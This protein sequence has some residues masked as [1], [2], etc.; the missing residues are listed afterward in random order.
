MCE[1]CGKEWRVNKGKLV[2]VCNECI[3]KCVRDVEKKF[4][5]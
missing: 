3:V 2:W 4:K 1:V 5:Q